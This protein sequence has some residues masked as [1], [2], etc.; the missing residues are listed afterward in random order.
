[1]D[2]RTFARISALVVATTAALQV[3]T[4]QTVRP[5]LYDYLK[6][7]GRFQVFVGLSKA[8]GLDELFR[9]ESDSGCTVVVPTDAAFSHMSVSVLDY[10]R[11]NPDA[12]RKVV[13][14]HVLPDREDATDIKLSPL[15]LEG[16]RL[17]LTGGV[18]PRT[19]SVIS[20]DVL[21]SNGTIQVIDQVLFPPAVFLQLQ[22]DGAMPI[23]FGMTKPKKMK[24]SDVVTGEYT[25]RRLATKP[26]S[27]TPSK[28]K[29]RWVRVPGTNERI[30]IP[31]QSQSATPHT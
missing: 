2:K 9:R 14:Y 22:R 4:A 28:S 5:T 7:D 24:A 31:A 3:A 26:K 27:K 6:N 1:M 17:N 12:L 18:P 29:G 8:A 16:D 10:L 25:S 20:K 15:T 23:G 19:A 11:K 21:T 13:Q 30:W